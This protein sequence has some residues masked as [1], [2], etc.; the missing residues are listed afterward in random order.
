M[1]WFL[2]M[3]FTRNKFLGL[4]VSLASTWMDNWLNVGYFSNANC[5]SHIICEHNRVDLRH[6]AFSSLSSIGVKKI[7]SLL[8]QLILVPNVPLQQQHFVFE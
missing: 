4:V 8:E 3:A 5:F 7:G 2:A 1:L 6:A